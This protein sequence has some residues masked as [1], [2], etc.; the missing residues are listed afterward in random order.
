M[1]GGDFDIVGLA[2]LIETVEE[3]GAGGYSYLVSGA[4]TVLIHLRTDLVGKPI[5][6]LIAGPRPGIASGLV[7]ETRE[8]DRATYTAFARVPNLP[9]S[10]DGYIALSVDR[11][12]VAAPRWPR[13][14]RAWPGTWRCP[15]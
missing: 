9:P 13:P 6:D 11:A 1:I 7:T 10:L 3:T 2:R 12:Q 8:G 14:S 4:G 15:P 5:T